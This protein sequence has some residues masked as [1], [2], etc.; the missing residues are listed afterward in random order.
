MCIRPAFLRSFVLTTIALSIGVLAACGPKF[1][2]DCTKP[3]VHCP[4]CTGTETFPDPCAAAA[5]D[6]GVESGK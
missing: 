6:A 2:P 3:G 5:R 1:F 4:P